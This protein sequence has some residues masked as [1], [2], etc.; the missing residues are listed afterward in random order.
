MPSPQYRSNDTLAAVGA[1]LAERGIRYTAARRLVVQALEQAD[2]PLS[3]AELHEDLQ[4]E[5]PL[6]SLYRTL[7]V[8]EG[9]HVIGR[10]HAV[11][12]VA[13]YEL[14][15]SVTGRHHHHLVCMGCGAVVDVTIP[16][17]LELRVESIITAI[18]ERVGFAATGHRIDIEGR[19]PSCTGE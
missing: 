8:L 15:E 11:D 2:G 3:A 19:C 10:E 12:G 17:D 5:V 14:A 16:A 9:A 4:R 18:A 6:S 13:R 7:S 1:R